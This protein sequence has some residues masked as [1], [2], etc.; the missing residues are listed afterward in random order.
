MTLLDSDIIADRQPDGRY[1]IRR[2]NADD[3]RLIAIVGHTDT[4]D[5]AEMRRRLDELRSTGDA[6]VRERED[7]LRLIQP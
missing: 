2:W 5:E 6:Y 1:I 7:I 3:R 4:Y